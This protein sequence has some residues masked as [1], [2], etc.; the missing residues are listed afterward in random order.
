M[1]PNSIA[2]VAKAQPRVHHPCLV[3]RAPIEW[4]KRLCRPCM[5]WNERIAIAESKQ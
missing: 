4:S 2:L 3:C 5:W 1:K